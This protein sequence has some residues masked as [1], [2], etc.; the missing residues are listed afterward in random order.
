MIR[1]III[2]SAIICYLAGVGSLFYFLTSSGRLSFAIWLYIGWLFSLFHLVSL[3]WSEPLDISK[4]R[5]RS[6]EFIFGLAGLSL[7][8]GSFFIYDND[9]LAGN[10]VARIEFIFVIFLII[11]GWL[12]AM[13]GVI[14]GRFVSFI[15]ATVS[16]KLRR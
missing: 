8:V 12:L 14:L 1:R 5:S 9:K 15:S 7:V 2:S 10:H 4:H 11:T 6:F 13:L 16:R 3:T